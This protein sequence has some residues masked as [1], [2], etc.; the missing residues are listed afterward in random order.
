MRG[1]PGEQELVL[2]DRLPPADS[3]GE[4][5]ILSKNDSALVGGLQF[6]LLRLSPRDTSFEKILSGESTVQQQICSSPQLAEDTI[7]GS[8]ISK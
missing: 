7:D 1:G 6:H 3:V 8:G 2:L 4:T 5:Q